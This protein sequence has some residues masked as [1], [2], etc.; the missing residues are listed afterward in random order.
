MAL[1]ESDVYNKVINVRIVNLEKW[2]TKLDNRLWIMTTLLVVN[3]VGIIGILLKVI[4]T[5]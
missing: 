2:V 5:V 3:L 4:L 1:L